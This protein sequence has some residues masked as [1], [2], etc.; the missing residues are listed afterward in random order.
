MDDTLRARINMDMAC[1]QEEA[2][3]ADYQVYPIVDPLST[4][5]QTYHYMNKTKSKAAHSYLSLYHVK[6]Q[7]TKAIMECVDLWNQ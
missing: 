4:A 6:R 1:Q 5:M 7:I 2:G 3:I